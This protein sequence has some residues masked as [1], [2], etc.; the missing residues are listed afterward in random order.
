MTESNILQLL[1]VVL[2]TGLL[3][4]AIKIEHRFTKLET[5]MAIVLHKLKIMEET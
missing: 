2:S 3:I 1:N 4:Y 5:Q